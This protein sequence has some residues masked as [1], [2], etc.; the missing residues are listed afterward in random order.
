M[1][2]LQ[3]TFTLPANT[4]KISQEKWD[5]IFGKK[6]ETNHKQGIRR[7]RGRRTKGA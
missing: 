6:D 4:S 3:K 1:K 2:Y 5:K 7:G